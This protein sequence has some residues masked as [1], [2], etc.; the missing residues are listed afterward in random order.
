MHSWYFF[1]RKNVRAFGAR[2]DLYLYIVYTIFKYH[3]LIISYVNFMARVLL[4]KYFPRE[5]EGC[6]YVI[7][8]VWLNGN[9]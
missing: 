3:D 2:I 7:L 6:M 8:Y 9:S 5:T 1:A 4:S